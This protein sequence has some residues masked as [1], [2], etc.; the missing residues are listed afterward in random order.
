[1][2][3]CSRNDCDV[4]VAARNYI[5]I[6]S[7]FGLKKVVISLVV[8]DLSTGRAGGI[9]PEKSNQIVIGDIK[10]M[11]Y[12]T[13]ILEEYLVDIRYRNFATDLLLLAL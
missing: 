2:A 8:R 4:V 10:K 7:E 3:T 6:N 12:M 13:G 11:L 9:V 5:R 1:M